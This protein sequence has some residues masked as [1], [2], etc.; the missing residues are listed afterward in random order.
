MYLLSH[1]TVDVTIPVVSEG[2]R[3]RLSTFQRGTIFGEMGLVD[4]RPRAAS[5]HA[6]EPV[7]CWELSYEAFER[8][9]VDQPHIALKVHNM[10]GRALGSRLRETNALVMELDG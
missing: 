3:R 2:W 4:G 5:V 9:G 7:R 6:R 8:L 1:G 10:I